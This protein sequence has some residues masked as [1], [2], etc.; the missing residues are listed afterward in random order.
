MAAQTSTSR[1]VHF[2]TVE[3]PAVPC[4]TTRLL[5]EAVVPIAVRGRHPSPCHVDPGGDLGGG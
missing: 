4:L 3:I 1:S 5:G 2:V